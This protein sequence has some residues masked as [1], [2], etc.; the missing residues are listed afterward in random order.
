MS[1]LALIPI[2]LAPIIIWV[3]AGLLTRVVSQEK[4]LQ[5]FTEKRNA[6]SVIG[7]KL[8]PGLVDPVDFRDNSMVADAVNVEVRNDSKAQETVKGVGIT[9]HT[10]NGQW[11]MP[12]YKSGQT[13]I[14]LKP[15]E[16]K[17]F[18]LGYMTRRYAAPGDAYLQKH[19]VNN[20]DR[21]RLSSVDPAE[22]FYV[23]H[24]G[25]PGPIYSARL[26][27]VGVINGTEEIF[28]LHADDHA[29]IKFS[30]VFEKTAV[31]KFDFRVKD[32][33]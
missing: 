7:L 22:G 11:V 27:P 21:T 23:T 5:E 10:K 20:A 2:A 19:D 26:L 32:L 3:I 18:L 16:T 14:S 4:K 30:I 29:P 17:E 24:A 1:A 13:E 12:I 6:L 33:G 25:E 31:D 8:R 15:G 28:Y 9:A